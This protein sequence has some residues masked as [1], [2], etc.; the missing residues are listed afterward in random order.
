MKVDKLPQCNLVGKKQ[1]QCLSNTAAIIKCF[2]PSSGFLGRGNKIMKIGSQK[3]RAHESKIWLILVNQYLKMCASLDKCL[4]IQINWCTII[5]I[6]IMS[7]P[8]KITLSTLRS[9][10]NP[11]YVLGI[12][13]ETLQNTSR[14]HIT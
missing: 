10:K 6:K 12:I 8:I 9:Y 1:H 7:S 13:F 4:I 5:N 14:E 11:M 2:P 3:S